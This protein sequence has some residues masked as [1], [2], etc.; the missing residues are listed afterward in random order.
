VDSAQKKS[1]RA[2]AHALKP[3]I[4]VGQSGL[5]ESV[6]KE[7]EIT[8]DTHELIKI[9]IRAEKEERKIICDRIIEAT[10]AEFIQSIG[11]IIVIFRKR[12]DKN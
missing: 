3:V 5:T 1:L 8:L 12:K 7:I 4:I 11:Q 9:K 6:L 2:K 10:Q